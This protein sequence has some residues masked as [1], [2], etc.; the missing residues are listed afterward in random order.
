EEGP[1]RKRGGEELVLH[2]RRVR[3]RHE[4][5]DEDRDPE[6]EEKRPRKTDVRHQPP[7][8][9]QERPKEEEEDPRDPRDQGHEDRQDRQLPEDI[10]GA[11]ERAAEVERESVVGEVR[12][13]EGQADE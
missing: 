4:R 1:E 2:P 11:R 6:A 12:R 7:A 9:L 10:F 8:P 13:D 3:K 5:E